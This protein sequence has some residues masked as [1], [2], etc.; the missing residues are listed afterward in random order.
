MAS[1]QI[2][3]SKVLSKLLKI[4]RREVQCDFDF[5]SF[6]LCKADFFGQV[7][8]FC[9]RP[10]VVFK[11]HMKVQGDIGSIS[12]RASIKGALKDFINHI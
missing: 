7:F 5:A 12:P 8:S 4:A 6:F 1:D 3:L 2:F 10:T 9:L 11:L